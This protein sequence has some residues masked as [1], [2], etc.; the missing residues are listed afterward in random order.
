MTNHTAHAEHYDPQAPRF[1]MWLFIF[2]EMLL[3]GGLFIVYS[4]YRYMYSDAFHLAAKE[5]NLTIGTINTLILL[6]SSTLVSMAVS[7]IQ[8]GDKK[9]ANILII[10]TLILGTVFLV[11]KYFEW[12][13]KISHGLFPG[14]EKLHEFG[15]GDTLFFGLYFAMTGLHALH[16]II[17][18]IIWVF[19]LGFLSIGKISQERPAFIEN[20]GLYWHLIDVVWIFLFS[21]FYLIT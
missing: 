8:K 19:A 4:V 5:I 12:G 16:M 7:A 21:L 18:L 20:A 15:H 10:F 6:V 13:T 14:S 3:F 9:L 11:N 2:T 17:G 1:G